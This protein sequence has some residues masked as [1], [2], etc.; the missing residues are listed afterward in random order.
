MKET[1]IM[2]EMNGREF[3]NQLKTLYPDIR[4]L[5]MSGYTENVIAHHNVLK[6][7]VYFIEKPFTLKDI[8]AMVR[9]LLSSP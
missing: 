6:D 4:I 2:P 9:D 3:A 1:A 8:A 5:F 7:G